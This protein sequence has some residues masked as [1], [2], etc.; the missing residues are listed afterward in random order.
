MGRFAGVML[1]LLSLG[2]GAEEV[3]PSVEENIHAMDTDHDGMVTV[4]EVRVFLEKKNGKGYR[5]ELLDEMEGK[6]RSCASPFSKS[7]F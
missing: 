5:Q 3:S 2:A 1:L 7:V 6:G 4:H